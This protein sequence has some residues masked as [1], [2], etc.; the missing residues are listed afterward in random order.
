MNFSLNKLNKTFFFLA[1][2]LLTLSCSE[3]I[4]KSSKDCS[5]GIYLPFQEKE[6]GR[7]GFVNFSGEVFFLPL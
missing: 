1:S 5:E 7:W 4:S 2:L 3:E 6:G